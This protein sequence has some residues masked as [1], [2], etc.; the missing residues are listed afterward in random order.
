MLHLVVIKLL[1]MHVKKK[2]ILSCCARV[3][4]DYKKSSTSPISRTLIGWKYIQIA[5]SLELKDYHLQSSYHL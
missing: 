3:L 4:Q 2:L 5:K 1:Y